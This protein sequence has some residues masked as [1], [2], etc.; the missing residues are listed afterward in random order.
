MLRRC[1]Q[2]VGVCSRVRWWWCEAGRSPCSVLVAWRCSDVGEVTGWKVESKYEGRCRLMV[3]VMV[4]VV[5]VVVVA[6][7]DRDA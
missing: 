7:T 1:Q 3:V 6:V 4:M 5:V 2:Q